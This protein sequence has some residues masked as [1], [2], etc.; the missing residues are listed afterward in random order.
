VN[1]PCF[2]QIPPGGRRGGEDTSTGMRAR[3]LSAK[4][5]FK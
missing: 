2:R 5:L 4:K 1:T 3:H